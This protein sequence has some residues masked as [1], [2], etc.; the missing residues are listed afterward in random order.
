MLS[1]VNFAQ[2]DVTLRLDLS[3]IIRGASLANA[4]STEGLDEWVGRPW[5]DTVAEG[6]NVQVQQMIADART[7]GVSSFHQVRQR[8]PSG[9]EVAVEYTTVRLGGSAGLIAIGRNLEVVAE[10]RSRLVAA[11]KSMERD[12]WKLREVEMRYRLLFDATT[13]P[14]LLI[15]LDDTRIVEANPAAI[16]LL[17]V[18]S[19]RELLPEIL[20]PQRELFHA[21]LARVREQGKAPGIILH[22][23]ADR[24]P[25]MVRASLIAAEPASVFV[26][27]LAPV[28]GALSWGDQSGDIKLEELLARLQE[29]FLV[30]DVDGTIL[31]ANRAFLEMIGQAAE[32]AVLGQRLSRW[33]FRPGADVSVL[34]A[35]IRRSRSIGKFKTILQGELGNEL[36]VEISAAGNADE[37]PRDVGVLLRRTQGPGEQ[38]AGPGANPPVDQIGKTPLREIVQEAVASVER[39]CIEAALVLA[40]GNRTA[41]AEMLGL[42]RQSLYS[43]LSR[44]SID[45]AE[46]NGSQE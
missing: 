32:S 34:L 18:A 7:T 24:Q 36:D 38:A 30:I 31:R 28:S 10:L 46:P 15:S 13:Q 42:S 39:R 6:G 26:L 41:A 29:G 14:V 21:M 20:T 11:Q 4:I 37:N 23:G 43:K 5:A 16:R 12:Y 1:S 45:A 19:D 33:I 44:Y 17:G 9:L 8:F 2:P 35:S 22:L 40:H 3:G 27:Q 25:W